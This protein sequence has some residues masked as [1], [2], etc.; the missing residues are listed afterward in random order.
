M[1]R[2][3]KLL[4]E[5]G[6]DPNVYKKQQQEEL[7]REQNKK[8]V[9]DLIE[10]YLSIKKYNVS[11]ARYKKNYVGTFK[12]YVIL[13]IG[14][15]FINEISKDDIL[16]LVKK[17][18][19]MKLKNATRAGNKT[20]KAKEVLNIVKDMFEFAVDNGYLEYNPAYSIKLDRIL[21]KHTEKHMEAIT[22][23][24]ELK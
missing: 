24:D 17:V 15:R 3:A 22:N 20:Y 9:S 4:L 16:A 12:N 5:K 11:E 8:R 10:E 2:E 21:P 1:A 19:K 14:S 13:Y 7:I 6:I 18:P 23:E